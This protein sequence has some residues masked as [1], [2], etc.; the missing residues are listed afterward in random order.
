MKAIRIL[1]AD[2]HDLMR[3]GIRTLLQTHA[4]W[5]ICGEANNG[6]EAVAKAQ[7]LK[8]DIAILDIAMPDLNGVDAAKRIRKEADWVLPLCGRLES[9]Y[10]LRSFLVTAR[11][12]EGSASLFP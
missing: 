7:E 11:N 5:E 9:N 8:P 2:D 6:R 12:C 4:G 1:I 10:E 3:R